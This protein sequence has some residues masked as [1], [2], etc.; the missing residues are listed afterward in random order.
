MI[1]LLKPIQFLGREIRVL[2]EVYHDYQD[3]K[4]LIYMVN[5]MRRPLVLMSGDAETTVDGY[6]IPA[7]KKDWISDDAT[8]R[9]KQAAESGELQKCFP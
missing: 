1:T 3:D 2:S 9:I 8:A 7:Y 4:K 6:T 5:G